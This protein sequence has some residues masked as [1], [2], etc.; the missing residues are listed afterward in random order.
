MSQP[1][2]RVVGV[3]TAGAAAL[4]VLAAVPPAQ[5][6]VPA[7]AAP[8][9]TAVRAM[10]SH[11]SFPVLRRGDDGQPV[12]TLQYL[13]RARGRTVAVDGDFGR[14]TERAVRSF[15]ASRGLAVDGVVG[16]RTWSALV[17]TVRRGSRGDAV[18]AVQDQAQF[19]NLSGDPSRGLA[20]DGV[21]GPRTE[22]FVRAFQDA[23]GLQV[24]GIVGPRTWRALI[25]GDLAG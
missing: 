5:A 21:F 10:Q 1:R 2:V 11:A 9:G 13:L 3:A 6:G 4:A 15:Q 7:P 14:A 22:R 19:R 25:R 8:A 20:V 12:R 24:D 23:D 17:V 18:R 16:E